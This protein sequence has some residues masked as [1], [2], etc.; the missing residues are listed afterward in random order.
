MPTF[1]ED[2]YTGGLHL[3]VMAITESNLYQYVRYVTNTPFRVSVPWHTKSAGDYDSQYM[4]RL[5]IQSLTCH[6]HSKYLNFIV[7]SDRHRPDPVLSPELL[8]QGSGHEAPPDVR[9]GREV[10]LPRLGPV[11]GD[12]F[13]QFHLLKVSQYH[14][15]HCF[16]V[17]NALIQSYLICIIHTLSSMWW[18]FGMVW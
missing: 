17:R 8:R 14:Y 16:Q 11:R 5:W 1:W 7:L 13:I 10:P 3:F 15:F 6:H 12:V 9:G 4:L 2:N 18:V